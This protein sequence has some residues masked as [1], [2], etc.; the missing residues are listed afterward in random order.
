MCVS[1][2]VYVCMYVCVCIS[3]LIIN[4][5]EN[6][7]THFAETSSP[8]A[9]W[10]MLQVSLSVYHERFHR[11][12]DLTNRIYVHFALDAQSWF[13]LRLVEC[14][15]N[16]EENNIEPFLFLQTVLSYAP[17]VYISLTCYEQIERVGQAAAF[18]RW[19]AKTMAMECENKR[20]RLTAERNRV[21]S[22][23][24]KCHEC[25]RLRLRMSGV[26]HKVDVSE[27]LNSIH[28]W[29]WSIV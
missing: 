25:T 8:L 3:V 18:A 4:T 17:I 28:Q 29:M 5:K 14:R 23:L 20:G 9:I 6:Q 21:C 19:F 12:H 13:I 10:P 7:S 2:N 24:N 27:T 16:F 15:R 22:A 26:L 1:V 11:L